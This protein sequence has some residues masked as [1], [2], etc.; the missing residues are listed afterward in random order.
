MS[1]KLLEVT[2]RVVR[3]STR[4]VAN[5]GNNLL[6]YKSKIGWVQEGGYYANRIMNL[7]KS[8]PA[9]LLRPLKIRF[10]VPIMQTS[11]SRY[12]NF[13]WVSK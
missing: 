11:Y 13:S 7:M 8:A 3:E 9:D 12:W 6:I 10:T 4:P 2:A 1:Q 5:V